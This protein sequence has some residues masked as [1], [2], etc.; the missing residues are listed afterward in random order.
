MIN[1]GLLGAER[2][3]FE[4]ALAQPHK[5]RV[6]VTALNMD[7]E[8]LG[9][10]E[11]QFVDGQVDMAPPPRRG[12]DE[13]GSR[14]ATLTLS[15]PNHKLNLDTD[16]VTDG[17]YYLNRMLRIE[18]G[19]YVTAL[20]QW[21]DVP[22]VEGPIVTFARD[23]DLLELEVHGKELLAMR[24]AGHATTVHRKAAKHQAIRRLLE[25]R[26]GET[27]FRLVEH[28]SRLPHA[29]SLA[30]TDPTLPAVRRIAASMDCQFFYDAAGRATLR[31]WPDNA[32]FVFGDDLL[33]DVPRVSNDP[34][35]LA[36]RVSVAGARPRTRYTQG[37]E[38]DPDTP[39]VDETVAPVKKD[40]PGKPR[41]RAVLGRRHPL[42]PWKLG[43]VGGPSFLDVV[44][45]DAHVRSDREAQRL[46]ERVLNQ[47]QE[48]VTRIEFETIPVPHLEAGDRCAV[49]HPDVSTRF[50]I[51]TF[52]FPLHVGEG[53]AAP[54]TVGY[55]APLGIKRRRIN[56]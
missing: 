5:V 46:A 44:L 42:S 2:R 54:M 51:D 29:V 21:V 34:A 31:R 6:K 28:S 1:L 48:A 23:G 16:Q 4:A 7:A 17:A 43:P 11:P 26:C 47:R 27:K 45:D 37:R 15:D 9:H 56:G 41:G 38:D 36:N 40:N 8:E 24:G 33:L 22:M 20:D 39:N 30:A 35:R 53:E 3:K 55:A 14:S 19:I 13:T 32:V 50:R 12:E 18:W 49:R 52:S 25:R 10:L